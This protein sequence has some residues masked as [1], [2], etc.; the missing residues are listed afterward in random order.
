MTSTRP[1]PPVPDAVPVLPVADVNRSL[2]WYGRLGFELR[3]HFEVERYAI[4]GFEGTEVHLTEVD[5]PPRSSTS[6]CYL[7]VVDADSLHARWTALGA[8]SV[9]PPA[10]QPYGMHEFATEDPDGNLWR[11]GSPIGPTGP[12]HVAPTA[13]TATPAAA[14]LPAD[15]SAGTSDAAWFDIVSSSTCAG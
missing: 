3:T 6:G 15:G 11:V 4:L 7:R 2:L 10:D 13:A 12:E 5:M 8:T 14:V 1:T 9:A